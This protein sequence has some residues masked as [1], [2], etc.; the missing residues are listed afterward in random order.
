M[1]DKQKQFD[2][3]KVD[4]YELDEEG[5]K[6]VS[7]KDKIRAKSGLV[8]K[9][10]VAIV[11]VVLAIWFLVFVIGLF[12]NGGDKTVENNTRLYIESCQSEDDV[13]K[14]IASAAPRLAQQTGD[15][16]YC[17]ELEGEDYDSCATLSAL[18]SLDIN[19]CKGIADQD[20]KNSCNDA[21][22][23]QTLGEDHGYEDCE[24]YSDSEKVDNCRALWALNAII[25]GNCDNEIISDAQCEYGA[26][27]AEAIETRDPAPC[28]LVGIRDYKYAC[29][30]MV[31][32]GDRDF[33][34]LDG[35]EED[36]YGTSDRDTD[37][38]DDGLLDYD[39][40]FEHGTDP[41]DSDTDNDGYQDGTEVIGGYDPLR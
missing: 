17:D 35:D 15:I 14:C 33:D 5:T 26:R 12:F 9:I 4:W 41:A 30:E 38:D 29:L 2:E 25:E 10:V 18:T 24:D 37:S 7:L 23:T 13:D 32:P 3:S 36:Y 1:Q 28:Y 8:I 16:S 6:V 21:I 19:D 34:E 27:I 11:A 20:K 31:G 39:E 22:V 40:V